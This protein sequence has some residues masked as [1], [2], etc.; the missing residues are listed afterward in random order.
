MQVELSIKPTKAP[1]GGVAAVT[2]LPDPRATPPPTDLEVPQVP[3]I[4]DK[5]PSLVVE[6]PSTRPASPASSDGSTMQSSMTAGIGSPGTEVSRCAG[7]LFLSCIAP[8]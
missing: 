2:S 4:E 3:H 5:E 6:P 1:S 8:I 7:F